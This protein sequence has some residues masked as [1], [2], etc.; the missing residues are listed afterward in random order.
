[1]PSSP[2]RGRAA[3]HLGGIVTELGHGWPQI[4]KKLAT[5]PTAAQRDEE[6]LRLA[7]MLLTEDLAASQDSQS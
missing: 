5:F 1:M 3:D 7:N 6:L 4:I 2:K